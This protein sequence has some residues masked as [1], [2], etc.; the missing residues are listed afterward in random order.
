[1]LYVIASDEPFFQAISP[2]FFNKL[3]GAVLPVVNYCLHQID[4]RA[5]AV[6]NSRERLLHNL[7]IGPLTWPEVALLVL[8]QL[9]C[10]PFAHPATLNRPGIQLKH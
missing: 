6:H 9:K 4:P 8:P 2:S 1:M 5:R 3:R 7:L 10:I